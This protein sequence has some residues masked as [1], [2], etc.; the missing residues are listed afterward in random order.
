MVQRIRDWILT[1][2]ILHMVQRSYW[3]FYKKKLRI[4]HVHNTK[5]LYLA[6]F[7][8]N[9]ISRVFAGGQVVK[10]YFSERKSYIISWAHI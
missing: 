7:C 6:I 10:L 8:E 2:Y 4:S 3:N 5:V 1:M 9:F